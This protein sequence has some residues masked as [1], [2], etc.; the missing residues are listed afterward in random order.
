LWEHAPKKLVSLHP[1]YWPPKSAT[2]TQN[3]FLRHCKQKKPKGSAQFA[4]PHA[5]KIVSSQDKIK[6]NFQIITENA[7]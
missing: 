4:R 1:Q 3:I 6:R 7:V 2:L 5:N